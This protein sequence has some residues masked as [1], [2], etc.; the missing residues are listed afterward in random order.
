[1][2][3]IPILDADL[4]ENELEYFK[5]FLV[6]SNIEYYGMPYVQDTFLGEKLAGGTVM[7]DPILK[8]KKNHSEA[9]IYMVRV[10]TC[11]HVLVGL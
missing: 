9:C 5:H 8:K 3:R 6:Q 11:M 10:H 2:K 7:Y 4:F 1:M